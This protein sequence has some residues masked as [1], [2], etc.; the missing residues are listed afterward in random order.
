MENS[1]D[2]SQLEKLPAAQALPHYLDLLDQDPLDPRVYGLAMDCLIACKDRDLALELAHHAPAYAEKSKSTLPVVSAINCY[3]HY[4][5]FAHAE[6]LATTADHNIWGRPELLPTEQGIKLCRAMATAFNKS[7]EKVRLGHTLQKIVDI[8]PDMPQAQ[9]Y[10]AMMYH[11]T[12]QR[13]KALELARNNIKDFPDNRDVMQSGLRVFADHFLIDEAKPVFDRLG[14]ICRGDKAIDSY[15]Y[16]AQLFGFDVP[17]NVIYGFM[18]SKSLIGKSVS[19]ALA[20]FHIHPLG[21]TEI[22]KQL[23]DEATKYNSKDVNW[24]SHS[25]RIVR[26][27]NDPYW[28]ASYCLRASK[29]LPNE[30]TIHAAIAQTML[31][32]GDIQGAN[33]YCQNALNLRGKSN[34][35]NALRVGIA[36]CAGDMDEYSRLIESNPLAKGEGADAQFLKLRGL[37][38]W[39]FEGDTKKAASYFSQCKGQLLDRALLLAVT[40]P[41]QDDAH[42]RLQSSM[43]PW[44]F[45]CVTKLADRLQSRDFNLSDIVFQL[46]VGGLPFVRDYESQNQRVDMLAMME[47]HHE[48]APRALP[49]SPS[50]G[51]LGKLH[52]PQG[53]KSALARPLSH[54]RG[55]GGPA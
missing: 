51:A 38:A 1:Y 35:A 23:I 6:T 54:G 7:S 31:Y 17:S 26:S 4:G 15:L 33:Q 48:L 29:E 19:H 55:Q 12:G 11:V 44:L 9:S 10:A 5:C 8:Y 36:F 13:D 40:D 49:T 25:L 45:G 52:F 42:A 34:S 50:A 21:Q 47:M 46:P 3:M 24:M 39:L 30:H 27:A 32:F 16:A 43:N 14:P 22:A 37:Y 28:A 18:R 2:L 20:S 41:Y 53:G